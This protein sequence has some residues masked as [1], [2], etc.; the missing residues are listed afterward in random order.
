MCRRRLDVAQ[1]GPGF[2]THGHLYGHRA[3]VIELCSGEGDAGAPM[4]EEIVD[5]VRRSKLARVHVIA[6]VRGSAA[7]VDLIHY[8]N[9]KVVVEAT[10]SFHAGEHLTAEALVYESVLIVDPGDL[11]VA[12]D[13]DRR[14]GSISVSYWPGERVV[15]MLAAVCDAPFGKYF[16][17][18]PSDFGEA[19]VW[20]AQT[21]D[22][23][24]Q[25]LPSHDFTR[26]ENAELKTM[27]VPVGP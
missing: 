6:A 15:R 22:A 9:E 24:W 20:L 4:Y 7:A 5:A 19:K 18:P 12:E 17:L 25:L 2:I 1:H 26:A 3:Y 16:V 8:L 27:G 21:G 23:E 14:A 13:L 11:F 10:M